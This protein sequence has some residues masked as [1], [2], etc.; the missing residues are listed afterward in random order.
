MWSLPTWQ[1]YDSTILRLPVFQHLNPHNI[2]IRIRRGREGA[3]EVGKQQASRTNRLCLPRA[4]LQQQRAATAG[5]YCPGA[6]LPGGRAGGGAAAGRCPQAGGGS[7]RRRGGRAQLGRASPRCRGLGSRLSNPPGP[8]GPPRCAL[9]PSPTGARALLLLGG[10]FFRRAPCTWRGTWGLAALGDCWALAAVGSAGEYNRRG[11]RDRLARRFALLEERRRR[12]RG[13]ARPGTCQTWVHFPDVERVEWLNKVLVQAWPYF[14]TIMEKTFKEVLEPKIR[15]KNVHLKTCT[16]TKIHF[17]EKCP[18]INGIKAYTKEIG[19]RQVTLDLQICYIGDCEIHMDISKFNLGV[20]GVQLYGTLRVILEPL[21]TDAPFVG[22]VTLFFMQKPHLEINWAGMSNLLDVPGINVMSDSLIQ[23]FIAARLVLPNRITVPLRKNMN[24]AHLRFPI[25]QGVIRVHLLEAENLVQKDSFLGAIRGKSD[26]YA[27]LRVGTVQHRSKTVSRDLNPIWNET[28]EFVVH[29]V[30]GQDL[31]VDLYDEDPD[32]DDFMGSL[33]IGLVDVM[34]D[35]T[36]DEWF[37]LS[38]TTSGHLHLKLEWLSLLNDQEKLHEDKKGLST[39]I[40]IVYL[41]SAFNLP[42]NHFEYSNGEC[43]AKKIKNNKY[44]KKMEREP[45]SFVLLT[46]GNKTQKSKTCNFSKDPTWGQAFTFFVHSAHSQSLHVEIKDKERDSALGTSVVCLS[47]LLKD[48]N[49]TLD[50]RFQ[51]DHSSSDSFIQMKLVLRALNVEEPDPDRVKAGVNASKQGPVRVMEKGGNQQKSVSPPEVS[52][53]PP[54]SKDSAALESLP[55]RDSGEDLAT[56]DC[57]AAPV[58]SETVAVPDGAEHKQNPEHRPPSALHSGAAAVPTLPVVQ[59]LRLAPS[60]T[61]LGSLPSSCFELSSSNLDIH[62]G[63]EMPLGE[64]QL[65]VRYASIRQSLVVLVNGCRNLVPSSSRGVDPY[66][67]IYLL[68]DRRWT[69]RKKTSVKKKTLNPQYDEKFEFF[70]SLENVKKRALDI[71]VKN[72]RP[73]ISQ[74]RKELGKV[75]I[76]LSQEDLIKGFAQWY[77]LT[78]SRRR[79]I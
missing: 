22:A 18:R 17:G 10:L 36:V 48:P 53:V 33:L 41:D 13:L 67:R 46:V 79:R 65:T 4:L 49:M 54:V 6:G 57:S 63:T 26:P 7:A 51:L 24:I 30:P 78:R 70:E 9:L 37:P 16:F 43:G 39:A 8:P 72:S 75:R 35:R 12:L 60:V 73:F 52:K 27:L 3:K 21:L 59:E 28:F 40:L 68:P 38:K 45:S 25:P 42:K 66:V 44:L 23:D 34:N 76:D 19:R 1:L 71:A 56:K 50:Q 77:E 20:K 74:E 29:E 47:H 58:P 31:E 64:I 69:S 15:A 14:G 61:S 11:K 2:P 55:K 32:K 62:N 5:L